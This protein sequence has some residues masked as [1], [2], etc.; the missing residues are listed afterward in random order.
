MIA[1]E[2]LSKRYDGVPVVDDVTFTC[3]RGTVTGFLGPNGAGKSTTLRMITGL[4]RPDHGHATV[5]GVPFVALPNPSRV[6]GTLLDASAMHPGRSGR[7][8]LAVAAHMAAVPQHRVDEVLTTVGL[9]PAAADKRV[10]TYSLGMRQRLGI[11]QTLIGHPEVLILDEP[12][13]GLDPEGIAWMRELLRDFADQGGTVLLSSHLLAEVEAT[14]DRLVVIRAGQVVADGRLADLLST[15]GLVA[16]ATDQTALIAALT[17]AGMP[18]PAAATTHRHHRHHQ[19]GHRRTGGI[20]GSASRCAPRRAPRRRPHRPRTTLLR[21]HQP[22]RDRR[23]PRGGLPMITATPTVASTSHLGPGI[24]FTRSLRVEWRKSI[25]TRAARWLL[26]SVVAVS[27]I[28]AIVPIA[29]P[30]QLRPRPLQLPGDRGDRGD[31]APARR[32]DPH[33]HLR[34]EPAHRPH[35]VHPRPTPRPGPRRQTRRRTRPRRHRRARRT[36]HRQRRPASL[37]RPRTSPSPG[38]SVPPSSSDTDCSSC[39]AA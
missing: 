37:R 29:T 7:N 3:H 4:T 13:N 25:D 8:T 14:V 26:A 28:A 27:V 36:R 34:M 17:G 9:S 38:T 23:R 11:A 24:P 2:S 22:S 39:S 12:A 32:V 6:V 16:R 5:A 1:A 10:G 33:P 31:P 19:W 20:G 35:H 15:T 18:A 21:P 30:T